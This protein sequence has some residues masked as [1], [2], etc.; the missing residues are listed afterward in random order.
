MIIILSFG[1]L[2]PKLLDGSYQLIDGDKYCNLNE[3]DLRSY[4]L[5]EN[6]FYEFT[7][8]IPRI[9]TLRVTQFL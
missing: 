5:K 8:V 9:R 7:F 2:T 1:Q 6:A 4:T 3:P